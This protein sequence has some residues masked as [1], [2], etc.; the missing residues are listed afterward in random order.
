M[1]RL[2]YRPKRRKTWQLLLELREGLEAAEEVS[3]G[4]HGVVNHGA[5]LYP[6]EVAGG[7]LELS[8][9]LLRQDV[10]AIL[11]I[12]CEASHHRHE[13]DVCVARLQELLLRR[14]LTLGD[15]LDTLNIYF[16]PLENF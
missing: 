4:F 9:V 15:L 3:E 8:L 1:R 16:Q 13:S 6:H 14:A 11:F 7:V 2:L 12:I 5:E 10:V